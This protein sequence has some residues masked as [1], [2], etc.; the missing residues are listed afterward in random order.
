M[1]QALPTTMLPKN[2][3]ALKSMNSQTA[4]YAKWY[5]RILDPKVVEYKFYAKGEA[6]QAQKVQCILVSNAPEQHMLGFG[7]FR[8]QG[9]QCGDCSGGK[10][11]GPFRLGDHNACL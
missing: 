7:A 11:H 8:L 4:K 5:V 1:G 9:P 3:E 6:V 2:T 10:A